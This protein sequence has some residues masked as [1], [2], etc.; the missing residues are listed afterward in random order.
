MITP[1]VV[2]VQVIQLFPVPG[3]EPNRGWVCAAHNCHVIHV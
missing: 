2:G 3:L 1:D